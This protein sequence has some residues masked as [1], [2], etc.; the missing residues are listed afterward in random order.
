ML[1]LSYDE[2]QERGYFENDRFFTTDYT[3]TDEEFKEMDAD[4]IRGLEDLESS[5]LTY[6]SPLSFNSSGNSIKLEDFAAVDT[7]SLN[8]DF[9]AA[10]DLN[11][12]IR[13]RSPK[14][15]AKKP[16]RV[17]RIKKIASRR[18]S[19]SRRKLKKMPLSRPITKRI[20]RPSILIRRPKTK[21]IKFY[22]TNEK[23]ET[24]LSSSKVLGPDSQFVPAQKNFDP[25]PEIPTAL[26]DLRTSIK[27]A[28][29]VRSSRSKL[30]FDISQQ[31][32]YLSSFVS[33]KKFSFSRLSKTPNHFKA[34][35]AS[36]NPGVRNNLMESENDYF[37]DPSTRAVAEMTF[38]SIQEIQAIV[39]YKKDEFGNNIISEPVWA[40][41]ESSM[42]DQDSTVICRLVYVEKP[43]IGIIPSDQFRLP[44][45]NA[46]F[47]VSGRDIDQQIQQDYVPKADLNNFESNN[48]LSKA[49]MFMTSNIIK[50][51][52]NRNPIVKAKTRT[53]KTANTNNQVSISPNA[54]QPAT[55]TPRPSTNR[56]PSGG[57]SGGMG[58]GSG[59]S[60]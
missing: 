1:L 58:G 3:I 4:V 29:Q 35:V 25:I 33:S 60:Y 57:S 32:N 36:R 40:P 17:K 49:T 43:E 13:W 21:A 8:R 48:E 37:I 55:S 52:Q 23:T 42:I 14:V 18:K 20:R 10:Q 34:L 44:V 45:Q 56:T 5:R 31:S 41:L 39:D 15:F 9:L 46:T 38:Q 12:K 16:R 22:E 50:Q 24:Y 53:I 19:K 51:K 26:V 7:L 54:Q 28:T 47:V 6:M 2:I 30:S 59:G 11:L 27:T